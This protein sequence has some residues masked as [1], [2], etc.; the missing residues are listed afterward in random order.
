M[1]EEITATLAE[2]REGVKLR[3]GQPVVVVID[4]GKG[5][6]AAKPAPPVTVQPGAHAP[7]AAPPEG[8]LSA[9]HFESEQLEHGQKAGLVV[10]AQHLEGKQIRFLVERLEGGEW[11]PHQTL[12][13]VVANGTARAELLASHPGHDEENPLAG[14][15]EAQLRFH[16]ELA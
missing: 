15:A 2:A 1:A 11:K 9:A 6:P 13:A 12:Q 14:G 7:P 4:D 5:E 16:A 8:T 3:T 10:K